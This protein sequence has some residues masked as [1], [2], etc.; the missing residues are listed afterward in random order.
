MAN[1]TIVSRADLWA[2]VLASTLG[3]LPVALLTSALLA[4]FLPVSADA[5]FAIGF[6]LAIPLWVT[7]MCVALLARRGTRALWLCLGATA[8]LALLVLAVPFSSP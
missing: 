1:R 8:L 5:R 6:A 4:R 7:A 2:L 3:T